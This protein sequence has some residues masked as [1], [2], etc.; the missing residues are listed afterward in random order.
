MDGHDLEKDLDAPPPPP[1]PR[2]G[3]GDW[4]MVLVALAVLGGGGAWWWFHRE[5]GP[6]PPPMA[7]PAPV[8]P[9][10]AVVEPVKPVTADRLRD[11]LEA[12]SV[13]AVFRSWLA[14]GD[15]IERWAVVTDN[16][17]EGVSPRARLRFLAPKDAF[18]TTRQGAKQVISAA[19]YARYDL[20][21]EAVGSVDVAAAV[22]AY[23]ELHGVVEAAYRALGYPE[24]SLDRVTAA[25]LKRLAAAPVRD[26]DVFVEAGGTGPGTIYLYT[27]PELE[28]LGPVEKQLLR[29][30][31][32]NTR[33]IQAKAR[34]LERALG[35]APA[36]AK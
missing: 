10:P 35:F 2:F 13:S 5:A 17:A 6:P 31:P 20:F 22:R 23:R 21:A 4:L 9:A 24:G 7:A 26:G 11:L 3:G 12:V 32:R 25:A 36:E 29:M 28:R 33:I 14:Q 34:Q 18:K 19:S 1:P 8:A 16:L 27:A 15:V 30:G